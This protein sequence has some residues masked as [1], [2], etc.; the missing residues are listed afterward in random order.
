MTSTFYGWHGIVQRVAKEFGSDYI[1]I[2]REW[3]NGI[4]VHIF[5]IYLPFF[6]RLNKAISCRVVWM[7][8]DDM[9]ILNLHNNWTS[10][11][12]TA[13]FPWVTDDASKVF[14][15]YEAS[16]YP[17]THTHAGARTRSVPDI[18]AF[19]IWALPELTP[20]NVRIIF[21]EWCWRLLRTSNK[22]IQCYIF[23]LYEGCF[24]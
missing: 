24:V 17:H 21:S 1:R 12:Y 16:F 10:F 23:F 3:T 5:K 20:E 15:L 6:G 14:F 18:L 9:Q 11:K 13:V 22:P 8:T 4:Y 2:I 19:A 7:I